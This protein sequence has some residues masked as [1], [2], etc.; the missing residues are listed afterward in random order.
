MNHTDMTAIFPDGPAHDVHMVHGPAKSDPFSRA[1]R[2]VARAPR[3]VSAFIALCLALSTACADEPRLLFPTASPP[4]AMVD[5][6][7]LRDAAPDLRL[8][9]ATLQGLVNAGDE[10]SVFLLL[11]QT[12]V[13]WRDRLTERGHLRGVRPLTS[14]EFFKSRAAAFDRVY[15]HD[16][17]LPATINVG[18]MLASLHRGIVATAELAPVLAPGKPVEDLRGRWKTAAEAYEWALAE[19]WPK[20]NPR[21]LACLYPDPKMS[22]LR[23]YLVRQRVFTFWITDKAKDAGAAKRE[24][25]LAERVM[26]AAPPNVPVLGF[27]SSGPD[28]GINEYD[29]VGL[30]G[31][32][33]KVTVVSDWASNCSLLSGIAVD[34]APL[35]KAQRARSDSP[36]PELDPSRVYIAFNVVE[37]GDASSYLETRQTEVWADPKRGSVPIGWGL[38]LCAAE[39]MPPVVEYYLQTATP[40]DRLFAAISGAGYTHPF[41][42][43]MARTPNPEAAWK[44]YLGITAGLM[45]RL[46]FTELGLY[47]DSWKPNDR[48]AREPVL[49]RFAGG[50]PQA[51]LLM[52]GMGR[53]DGLTAASATYRLGGARDTMVS[54]I[55][56]RW[57]ADYAALSKEQQID[58]LVREIQANTPAERPAFIQAMAL[59]WAYN[60]ADIAEVAQRLGNGYVPVSLPQY[61]ALWRKAHP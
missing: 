37:S 56:T 48:A 24:R 20:M 43:F 39:L 58:W 54:H 30:A 12:D 23:D 59:S 44:E 28:A 60:P 3:L 32:Y 34:F 57:P 51:A 22:G 2:K 42:N 61:A 41:R 7:D 52:P 50:V 15:V 11:S 49:R 29:G 13:F 26:A 6:V 21:V 18:T 35:V 40:N 38:G 14:G 27:W 46:G 16:P 36:L 33:G 47:T 25:A 8:A 4:A 19:L 53:D 1:L 31:E 9:A 17:A 10:A 45:D 55:L 5:V